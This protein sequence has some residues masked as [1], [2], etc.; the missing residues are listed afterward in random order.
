[1]GAVVAKLMGRDPATEIR[2][3][4]SRFKALVDSGRDGDSGADGGNGQV[5]TRT[6]LSTE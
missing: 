5:S 6:T 1:V 2:E 4:L 3:D